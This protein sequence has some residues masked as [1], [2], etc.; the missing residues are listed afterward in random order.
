M[1]SAGF[2]LY[3]AQHTSYRFIC[4][5][6]HEPTHHLF[7]TTTAW[8]FYAVIV[9]KPVD[10]NTIPCRIRTLGHS[11]CNIFLFSFSYWVKRRLE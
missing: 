1:V 2:S 10:C 3:S 6:I 8:Q 11:K 4:G 9:K 5:D 7:P